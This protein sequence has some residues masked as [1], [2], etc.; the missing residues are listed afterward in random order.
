M[1]YEAL[2]KQHTAEYRCNQYAEHPSNL[3]RA[4]AA[5]L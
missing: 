3:A 1:V 5:S 4:G 2:F